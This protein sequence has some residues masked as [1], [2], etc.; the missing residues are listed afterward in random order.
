[1]GC[2]FDIRQIERDELTKVQLFDALYEGVEG[3]IHQIHKE[4]PEMRLLEAAVCRLELDGSG[5]AKAMKGLP[6]SF[7]PITD[8]G[9]RQIFEYLLQLKVRQEQGNYCDFIR[10]L[11]R[12]C[13]TF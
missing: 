6:Q 13:S 3:I 11:T 10:G 1:M 12:S 9:Q 4:N 8:G 7:I 5:Y 2:R